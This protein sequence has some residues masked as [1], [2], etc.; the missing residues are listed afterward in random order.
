MTPT[1]YI[2]M[3]SNAFTLR[4]WKGP[5]KANGSKLSSKPKSNIICGVAYRQY[6]SAD[7]FLEYFEE[8]IDHYSATGRPVYLFGDVNVYILY[9]SVSD[10]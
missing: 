7:R 3:Y 10:L 9:S 6:N 8:S 2:L 4:N 1:T 5:V